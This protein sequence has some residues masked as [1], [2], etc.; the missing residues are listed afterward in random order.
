MDGSVNTSAFAVIES[1]IRMF[2]YLSII[3]LSFKAVQA[4]NIYIHKNSKQ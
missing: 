4:L 2:M 3:S 1:L